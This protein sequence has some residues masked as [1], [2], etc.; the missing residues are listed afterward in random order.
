MEQHI[1]TLNLPKYILQEIQ[2]CGC[3]YV[4][5]IPKFLESSSKPLDLE[6]ATKVPE[7]KTALD[8]FEEECLMGYIPTFTKELDEVLGGGIPIGLITEFA[9]ESDTCKTELWLLFNVL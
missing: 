5:D 8:V 9:G 4:C 2:N 3:N 1:S 6:T 7:T